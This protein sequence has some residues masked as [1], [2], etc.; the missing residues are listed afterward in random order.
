MS[1]AEVRAFGDGDLRV[2]RQFFDAVFGK[3]RRGSFHF[4][5]HDFVLFDFASDVLHDSAFGLGLHDVR[6]NLFRLAEAIG[7]A[8][9]LIEVL[10]RVG[11]SD[12]RDV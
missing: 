3:D 6:M 1:H 2:D 4:L 8:K 11:Q 7:P 12:K 5:L 9:R 10:K